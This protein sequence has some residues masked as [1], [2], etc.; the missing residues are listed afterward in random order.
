MQQSELLEL[1][2]ELATATA[3]WLA[4]RTHS[5]F[6]ESLLNEALLIIP[7]VEYFMSPQRL[8]KWDLKGEWHELGISLAKAGDVNIDL[9]AEHQAERILLEFK[10]LKKT[11]DQ[12]LIK[13]FVKLALPKNATYSRLLVIAHSSSGHIQGRSK[14]QLLQAIIA[15]QKVEFHL[16]LRDSLPEITSDLTQKTQKHPL[17]VGGEG[18]NIS[19]IMQYDPS[20]SDFAVELVAN[21]S[22]AQENVAIF[23]V[24]RVS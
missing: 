12:R 7:M 17:T 18:L 15:R 9:V 22:K 2:S 24:S 11:N 21:C 3:D 23:S 4:E 20:L 16:T 19:R 1:A 8:K 10:F 13:D 5:G 14:S 6:T